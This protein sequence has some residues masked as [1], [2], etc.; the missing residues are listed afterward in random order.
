MNAND[1]MHLIETTTGNNRKLH[2]PVYLLRALNGDTKAVIVLMRVLESQA[3]TR[4]ADGWCAMPYDLWRVE[5]RLSPSEVRRAV[6]VLA[7]FGLEVKRA[8]SA[9]Y[10]GAPVNHYRVNI[11]VLKQ[12][13]ETV[14]DSHE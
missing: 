6:D 3:M 2:I 13:L 8:Q 14:E 10:L 5:T 4:D 9:K 7:P 1:V 11:D 12:A